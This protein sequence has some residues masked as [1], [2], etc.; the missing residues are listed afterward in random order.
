M[1]SVDYREKLFIAFAKDD[2]YEIDVCNLPVGDFCISH[3]TVTQLVIER[4]TLADLSSSVIDNRFREQR[5][6]LIDS[7]TNPQKVLYIIESPTSQA[8][9]KGLS[10]KVLDAAVLNLLFKHNVKVLFT[11]SAQD[12]YE[13]V[14]LLHKKITEE[15][16]VPFQPTLLNVPT[17]QSRGQKLL[18]NVFLHQ[19]CVIPGVSPGIASHIV[20]IY[21]NA[22]S[23]CNAYSDLPEKSKWELLK[24]IQVTP[25]RKLGVKLSK[26]IYE[27]MSF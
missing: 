23:L 20:K 5:S 8:S 7:V 18:E 25:K 27:C 3:D 9:Y 1:L 14:K 24:E 15:F 12:T 4:K 16:I 2:N 10:K 13:K 26:K 19:L 11:F 21:P 22:M 6:R 17:V